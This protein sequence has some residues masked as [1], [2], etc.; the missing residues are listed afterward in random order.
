M[1][2]I[3]TGSSGMNI[4]VYFGCPMRKTGFF[5]TLMAILFL[6]TFQNGCKSEKAPVKTLNTATNVISGRCPEM[7]DEETRLDSVVLS[8]EGRLEYYYT[9]LY[10]EKRGMN[11]G[12]LTGFLI[13]SITKNVRSNPDLKMHRDSSV[14]MAFN[15]RDRRGEFVTEIVIK[16]EQYR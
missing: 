14:I 9:L 12:A 4:N 16:P 2:K 8:P 3:R 5:F 10:R 15:Y 7:V 1:K 6:L 11:T 13:P